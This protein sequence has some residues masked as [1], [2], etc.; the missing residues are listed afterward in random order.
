MVALIWIINVLTSIAFVIGVPGL[1][2]AMSQIGDLE[3]WFWWVS[4]GC[5]VP[6]IIFGILAWHYDVPPRWYWTKSQIDLFDNAVGYAISCGIRFAL[7]PSAVLLIIF[8]VD[9]F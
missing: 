9:Y 2:Y 8:I 5:F 7:I 3:A 1:F 4:L 6:G